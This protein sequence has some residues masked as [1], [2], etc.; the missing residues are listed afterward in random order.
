MDTIAGVLS[1]FPCRTAPV[2]LPADHHL[3]ASV[4]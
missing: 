3:A 1:P 2:W 4:Q